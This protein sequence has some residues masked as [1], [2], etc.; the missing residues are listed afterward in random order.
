VTA[1]LTLLMGLLAGLPI[2]AL[3]WAK[4]IVLREYQP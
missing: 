1:A 4:L 2:S 3:A